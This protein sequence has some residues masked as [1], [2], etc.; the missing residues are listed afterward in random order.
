[1][2]NNLLRISAKRILG[3]CGGG[4]VGAYSN[5]AG[6]PIIREDVARYIEKRDGIGSVSP[7]NIILSTGASGSITTLLKMLVNGP[8]DGIMIP[9]P[10]Y[11]LYS[12]CLAEFNATVVPYYLNE[13]TNWSLNLDEL[14]R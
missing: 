3:S 14:E 1:M 6:V 2:N 10:Q 5:S 13:E 12:A 9:I 4:S 7:D 11:P 8:Q